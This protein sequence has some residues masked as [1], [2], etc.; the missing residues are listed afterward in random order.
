[1]NEER[2]KSDR[3]V[4]PAIGEFAIQ[5]REKLLARIAELE[6]RGMH[7]AGQSHAQGHAWLWSDLRSKYG[8]ESEAEEGFYAGY[9]AAIT[10]QQGAIIVPPGYK[11]VVAERKT[12]DDFSGYIESFRSEAAALFNA[13]MDAVLSHAAPS[14]ARLN[15]PAD[16]GTTGDKYRAELYD[17]VWQKARDMGYGNV[18]GALIDLQRMKSSPPADGVV[19]SRELLQ[20]SAHNIAY[21]VFNLADKKLDD[22]KPGLIETSDPA[23]SALIVER[24]LRAL[25]AQQP[26]PSPVSG[27]IEALNTVVQMCRNEYTNNAIQQEA[28]DALAAYKAQRGDV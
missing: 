13:G 6:G 12:A 11:M 9:I 3:R 24:E 8:D 5:E 4:S 27:L 2:R 26:A 10:A 14:P 28:E 23:D 16:E 25:L 1:M 15:P 21:A 18:T 20:R 17:E 22:L 19:V 7:S